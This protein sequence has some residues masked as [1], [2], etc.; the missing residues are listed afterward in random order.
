MD[1]KAFHKASEELKRGKPSVTKR[2]VVVTGASSGI[3]K[4]I[5][6]EFARYPE[7]KVWATMRDPSK[8]DSGEVEDSLRV[9]SLDVTSD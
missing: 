7:Y 9:G 4:A 3:G 6:L 5:A 2:V 8:W 1:L